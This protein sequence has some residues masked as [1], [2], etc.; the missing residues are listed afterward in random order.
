MALFPFNP[1]AGQ[2]IQGQTKDVTPVDMAFLAH[3]RFKPVALDVD[4]ILTATTLLAAAQPGVAPVAQPD[5]PRFLSIQGGQAGQNGTVTIHGTDISGAVISEDIVSNAAVAVNGTKAFK[6]VT[7]IDLPARNG[8]GDTIVVGVI[9]TFGLPHKL[10]DDLLM[11]VKLFN[12][13]T[14]AG[15]TTNDATDLCKNVY[16]L[17]G[18]CDGAKYVDLYYIV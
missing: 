15:S 16:A 10:Q 12:L 11:L 8:V 2:T 14:D 5:V 9:N 1:F 3:Y 17:A 18:V 4:R 7:S 13:A 6:T